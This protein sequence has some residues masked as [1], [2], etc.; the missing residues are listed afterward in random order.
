MST[1]L[2][3]N[4]KEVKH[5][6]TLC[7]EDRL[8]PD[9]CEKNAQALAALRKA[10]TG[11]AIGAT[12]ADED[13]PAVRKRQVKISQAEANA[14][15]KLGKKAS[16]KPSADGK[17]MMIDVETETVGDHL[18]APQSAPTSSCACRDDLLELHRII[19]TQQLVISKL[20]RQLEFVLT[21]LEISEV[22][23]D[24]AQLSLDNPTCCETSNLPED[25]HAA[26]DIASKNN[27]SQL[28]SEVITRKK[29]SRLLCSNQS[30]LL[31]M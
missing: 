25:T 18:P 1:E 17:T 26:I 21:F 15:K 20:Q 16:S 30:L 27:G 12:A 23:T 14:V 24:V 19:D 9:C 10:Q 8:C 6:V 31:S 4:C 13:K 22:N 11:P 28:W 7:A 29:K 5:G 3:G 2:C